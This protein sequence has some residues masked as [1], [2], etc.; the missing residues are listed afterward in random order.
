[1]DR[2]VLFAAA[3]LHDMA[4]FQPCPGKKMEHGDCAA[5]ESESV[6]RQ[7]G[8]FAGFSWRYRRCPDDLANRREGAVICSG[9]ETTAQIRDR[10]SA[11]PNNKSR[12]AHRRAAG[13][14][15]ESL[16]RPVRRAD[17]RREGDVG[18]GPNATR[19]RYLPETALQFRVAGLY[20]ECTAASAA[21]PSIVALPLDFCVSTS[22]AWPIAETVTSKVT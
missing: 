7:A 20:V 8:L 22:V 18:Y 2:D 5:I 4:A 9:G 19:N 15:T 11:P 14:G 6:L 1:M 10:Y 16:S 12:P 13:G 21:A 3:F 17:L